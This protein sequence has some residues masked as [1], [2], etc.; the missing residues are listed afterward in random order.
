MA[1]N[2]FG[3]LLKYYRRNS[4]DSQKGGNLS[5]DRLADLLADES[6]ITYTRAA[7]SDWER[8]RGNIHKDDRSILTSLIK[9]FFKNGGIQKLEEANS[10]LEAGN[11]RTL[12]EEE[13][14]HI[15]TVWLEP[16]KSTQTKS[17]IFTAPSLPTH[18]IIGRDE[19][20]TKLKDQLFS[21]HNLALSAINGLPGVGKTTLAIL[22]ANDSKVQAR[23]PDGV[24]WVGLGRD[25]DTF[26]QLGQWARAVGI[27]D[28][29]IDQMGAVKQRANAI[30]VAIQQK[31]FLLI[32]D[33]VWDG[34]LIPLF[35][36][37]G[38]DCVHVLTTRQP[39]IA[40]EFAGNHVVKVSELSDTFAFELLRRLAPQ[41]VDQ[42]PDAVWEIVHASGGL[43]LALV[44]IGNHL[45]I[46]A[47]SGHKR[48]IRSA[49]SGLHLAENRF[50]L[51]INQA[52]LDKDA[53]PSLP[54]GMPI[55]LHTIIGVS[56]ET[57]TS[58]AQ[59]TLRVLSL[60]PPKPNSF[61]EEAAVAITSGIE[62]D[63]DKLLDALDELSDH[64]L[65]ET[66]G[67]DR[68][69]IHQSINEYAY[70]QL[71]PS[72][73]RV[74]MARYFT[75][76]V[77]GNA[78]NQ[79]DLDRELDNITAALEAAK[80]I[81][82]DDLLW[83]LLDAI[84]PFLEIRGHY[85][86]ALSYL[87]E[88]VN[89]NLPVAVQAR[90]HHHIGLLRYKRNQTD[91]A[92]INWERGL[93]LARS[94]SAHDETL[95][96]LS[97]LSIVTSQSREYAR[98]EEYLHEATKLAK[99]IPNWR[100]LCR[101]Q[102][103]LGRLA[104]I[105]DRYREADSFLAES[106]KIALAYDFPSIACAVYNMRGLAAMSL[107]SMEAA[108]Q[109]YFDGL[110]IARANRFDART[111]EL[112]TNLGHLLRESGHYGE[113]EL[114]LDEGL[115]LA[116][117]FED[118]AKEGHILMD[119]GIAAAEQSNI[120]KADTYMASAYE[121]AQTIDNRWLMGLIEARRGMVDINALRFL[122]AE[123]RFKS[124]LH[125]SDE[126]S[127]NKEVIGL[128]QFGLAQ[129]AYQ[130]DKLNEAHHHVDIGINALEGSGHNLLR[131]LKTWKSE[132]LS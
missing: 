117:Q 124:A 77:T 68:Y 8:G 55:S 52:V 57:L 46:Q 53:H 102:A 84:F 130:A 59:A 74:E 87:D 10:F 95:S 32:I 29:E 38:P 115:T 28:Q 126:S 99:S 22:L 48:R 96:L 132:K 15:T 5:Q 92:T 82:R 120:L 33:D 106:L 42:E 118:Q 31:R 60:F 122:E 2:E 61:S 78:E 86:L 129:L 90:I 24:L 101:A 51:E 93:M 125:W 20:L 114:Y 37:G 49:L 13:I 44:L 25:P 41:V 81:D 47:T 72:L 19:V 94:A 113:A 67:Q 116:R 43:P 9:T 64:G 75:K 16:N 39:P 7:I 27:P 85:D 36:I 34:T 18:D 89:H 110:Q 98:A 121:V 80:S 91:L 35:K 21:G 79:A 123:R 128:A 45:R 66:I 100:E 105:S 76:F 69:S 14:K 70:L 127:N 11:Y 104:I 54:S 108:R 17:V 88:L 103:N 40:S 6:G 1:Q 30:H 62:P 107:G 23:F 3:N 4:R 12:N 26:H 73:P 50:Q 63:T 112:L 119:L 71:T 65:L 56:D 83:D 109:H 131:E 97:H 58:V 111:L